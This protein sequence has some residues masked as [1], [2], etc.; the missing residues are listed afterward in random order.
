MLTTKTKSCACGLECH[1]N[2][3]DACNPEYAAG[4]SRLMGTDYKLCHVFLGNTDTLQ[5]GDYY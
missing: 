3:V 5:L 4:C 2:C 1:S